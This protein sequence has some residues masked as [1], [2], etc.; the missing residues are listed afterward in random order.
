MIRKK[1]ASVFSRFFRSLPIDY[2]YSIDRGWDLL[3]V[4]DACRWDLWNSFVGEYDFVR[5]SGVYSNART[6]TVWMEKN[7]SAM[8]T[9]ELGYICANPKSEKHLNAEDFGAL[10]EVWQTGWNEDLG[11]VPPRPVTDATINIMRAKQF[12]GIIAHYM[13]PHYPFIEDTH[14]GDGGNEV[15]SIWGEMEDGNLSFSKGEVWDAYRRNLNTVLEDVALLLRNVDADDVVIT[16]DHGNLFGEF[17]KY[18]HGAVDVPTVRK[19]PWV[20]TSA[21]DEKTYVPEET[22]RGV[23]QTSAKERLKDLGYVE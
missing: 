13:Q 21:A 11:T 4:L 10:K 17:E 22:E 8:D 3:I 23:M 1:T 19:V 5:E 12:E 2:G 6:T 15:Y 14:I 9:A 7:F 18:G 16:S 20:V